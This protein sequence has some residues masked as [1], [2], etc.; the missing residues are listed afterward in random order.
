MPQGFEEGFK[1][2]L[3]LWW[4]MI[5]Q[6]WEGALQVHQHSYCVHHNVR[7]CFFTVLTFWSC[8]V[9][10]SLSWCQSLLFQL[11]TQNAAIQTFYRWLLL[12][13]DS[14]SPW[15]EIL[16]TFQYHTPRGYQTYTCQA[17]TRCHSRVWPHLNLNTTW[18]HFAVKLAISCNM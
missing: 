11:G 18:S 3:W 16:H 1:W 14:F 6:S 15:Q 13:W 17:T 7:H 5:S 10:L 9:T 4:Y 8:L 12:S 2:T